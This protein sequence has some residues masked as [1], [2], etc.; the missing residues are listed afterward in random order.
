MTFVWQTL[1]AAFLPISLRDVP[2]LLG[3]F[4]EHLQRRSDG[5][6]ERH[7]ALFNR[8]LHEVFD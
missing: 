2:R 3:R 7:A 8:H 6:R 1:K 5:C 4:V